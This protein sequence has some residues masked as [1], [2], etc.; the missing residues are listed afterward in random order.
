MK[1][2]REKQNKHNIKNWIR[3]KILVN[4]QKINRG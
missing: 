3:W 2:E 4:L 1:K